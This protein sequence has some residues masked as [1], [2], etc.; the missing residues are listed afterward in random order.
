MIHGS[1]APAWSH[2]VSENKMIWWMISMRPLRSHEESENKMIHDFLAHILI[3]WGVG[4]Q[5]DT[6]FPC[7]RFDH[8]R[9]R[10]TKWYTISLR[11][12]RSHEESEK[13]NDTRFPCAHFDHMRSRKTKWYTISLRAFQSHVE[14]KNKMTRF[15]CATSITWGIGKQNDTR[16][17]CTRFDHTRCQKNKMIRDFLVPASI[18]LG[19]GKQNDTRFLCA[20]FDHMRSRKTKWYTIYLRPLRSHEESENKMI[21]DFLAPASITQGVG[22]TKWWHDFLAPASITQRVGKQNDKI[23][24]RPFRS[25]KESENKMTRFPCARFDHTKSRKTK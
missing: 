16:F 11:A 24:L 3:T 21:H 18:I 7:A 25:H 22:K 6:R 12:F 23:S 19:V 15:P 9:S 13:Q 8:M 4:K 5:N 2:E 20:L 17:P 10:K 14:S 1:L